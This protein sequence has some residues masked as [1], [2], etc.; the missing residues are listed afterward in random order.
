MSYRGINIFYLI[1]FLCT[2]ILIAYIGLIFFP[3]VSSY[4]ETEMESVTTIII[5]VIA[6]LIVAAC[7]QFFLLVK[8]PKQ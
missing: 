5:I 4:T 3:Q 2:L 6:L 8:P 7:I 1:S